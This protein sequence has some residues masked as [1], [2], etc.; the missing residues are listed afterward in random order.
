MGAIICQFNIQKE[1]QEIKI[2][3]DEYINKIKLDIYIDEE[4]YDFSKIYK[5]NNVGAHKI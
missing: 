4:K 2:L 5:F 3:G 1:N